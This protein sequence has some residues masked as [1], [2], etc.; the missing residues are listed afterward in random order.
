MVINLPK[1]WLLHFT[2]VK[3]WLILVKMKKKLG[4]RLKRD[5]FFT[6]VMPPYL[7]DFGWR[8]SGALIQW[9]SHRGGSRG[10][11]KTLH[12]VYSCNYELYKEMVAFYTQYIVVSA[13]PTWCELTQRDGRLKKTDVFFNGPL[14]RDLSYYTSLTLLTIAGLRID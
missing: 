14:T 13:I 2:T 4:P 3:P 5:N 6:N 12:R 7:S 1:T 11:W 9:G 8:F 10:S